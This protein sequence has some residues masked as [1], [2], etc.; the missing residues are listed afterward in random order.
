MMTR[1]TLDTNIFSYLLRGNQRISE[2][3]KLELVKGN[4]V[5]INPITYYEINR[6]L[7][8]IDNKRKLSVFKEMCKA[9]G[10]LDL[11]KRALDIA[12]EQYALL[13]KKGE[14]IEDAD[15]FI[16]AV[17]LANNLTLIT[18]NEKHFRRIKGLKFEN[19]SV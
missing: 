19:W 12:A 5:V 16:A 10:I 11:T 7:L 3:M 8:A 18:N 9:L 14:L 15:I 17:C 2:K 13:K 4:E 1:F 6:G